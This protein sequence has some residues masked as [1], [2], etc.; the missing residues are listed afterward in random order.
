MRSRSRGGIGIQA[1]EK[2]RGE[3]PIDVW[4]MEASIDMYDYDAGDIVILI[5]GY[6]KSPPFFFSGVQ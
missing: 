6:G 4:S 2:K 5:Y 1:P 3:T